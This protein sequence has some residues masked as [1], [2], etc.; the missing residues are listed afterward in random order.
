MTAGTRS[1]TAAH[2]RAAA[3][4]QRWYRGE[5]PRAS[6]GPVLLRAPRAERGFR[7][8]MGP[9]DRVVWYYEEWPARQAGSARRR[10]RDMQATLDGVG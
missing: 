1:G 8:L 7:A 2:A 10:G 3:S 4:G 9:A 6:R 5:D